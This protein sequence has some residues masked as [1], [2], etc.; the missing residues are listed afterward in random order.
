MLKPYFKKYFLYYVFGLSAIIIVDLIQLRIPMITGTITD[1]LQQG[2]MDKQGLMSLMGWLL[3]FGFS[4]TV[5]RFIWRNFIFGTSR[6]VEYHLRNDFF[7]HLETL[8]TSFYNKEKTG[9]L[10]AYATN[11][12]N[13][14]RML[15][16][17][18]ILMLLD[19]VVL[20]TIVVYQMIKT[21]DL[22]LTLLAVIPM[23]IIAILSLLLG[24][25]IRQRFD[26]K[27]EAFAYLSDIVQE[28]ISGIRVIKAFVQEGYEQIQ[29]EKTNED[30]FNKNMS[31]VKV[32]AL[33][34]PLA[35]L[36]TGVSIA[37]A[38]GYGGRLTMLGRI[39]LGEFVA[40][41]QYIMM[42]IWPMIAFG[43]FINIYSQ[44][45]ASV[46]RFREILDTVSDIQDTTK[47]EAI[48]NSDR[49]IVPME[50]EIRIENLT[51][52]YPDTD[53]DA[54]KDI[55]LHIK[56]GQSVGIVGRTGSGKTTLVNLLL[57]MFDA[58]MGT[59]F[60]DGKIIRE[61]FLKD[62]R[63]G[64]GYVPQDNFLFS[65]TIGNNISFGL[66]DVTQ[67]A[68]EDVA[69]KVDVHDNIMEFEKQYETIIGERG[70]TLS[71]GQ[72]Q[73]V[74]IARALI[75]DPALLILDDAVSAVDTKTEERILGHLRES[76]KNK[77]TITI[78]HRISTVQDADCIYVLEEGRLAEYGT[79]LELVEKE[80]IYYGM[81]MKQQLEKSIAETE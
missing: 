46:V 9:D 81:V 30:N 65:D 47:E 64:I 41:I 39:T 61:W 75:K 69:K 20:T 35:M 13:A 28:N 3:L 27:Q 71:G 32:H 77:T 49:D 58:P 67:E 76:R 36:I 23:P 4:I 57:R 12:L 40:F 56:K 48:T 42:L 74:S 1:G 38:L 5:L 63:Q 37:I 50:G 26:E 17:P 60:V 7:A 11:D 16:G 79:H 43:W 52:R 22:T 55:S 2:T 31:V 10:M 18:A 80:G 24:K 25:V 14:I 33:M 29:F 21:T 15:V 78:A 34:F 72:K 19:T 45:M 59:I 8:S 54:L 68:I 6:R 53:Q 51:F 44:G 70:V 66:D 62:L 73:R